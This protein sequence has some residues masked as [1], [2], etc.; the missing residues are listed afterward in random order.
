MSDIDTEVEA[1][2]V[3]D[4]KARWAEAWGLKV[5]PKISQKMMR[6]SLASKLKEQAGLGLSPEDQQKL[7]LLVEDYKKNQAIKAKLPEGIKPGTRLVR[8]WQGIK[9]SILVTETGFEYNG[10][11]YGSLSKIATLI[12]GTKWNGLVF[13]GIKKKEAKATG[14]AS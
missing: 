4:L 9:H 12:T 8:T 5:P 7:D 2:N 14:E 3:N 13:F 1:L 10:Q 11:T 6:K